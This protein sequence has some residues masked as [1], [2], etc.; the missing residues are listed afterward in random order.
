MRSKIYLGN[1]KGHLNDATITVDLPIKD[2]EFDTTRDTHSVVTLYALAMDARQMNRPEN[3]INALLAE[4]L[5]RFPDNH[6]NMPG[7]TALKEAIT[8]ILN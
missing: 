7:M 3:E 8:Q 1:L 4:A 6:E 5:S 2:E